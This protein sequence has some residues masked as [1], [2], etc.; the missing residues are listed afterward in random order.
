MYQDIR[1]SDGHLLFR[2][3]PER[4]IIEIVQRKTKTVVDLKD[5]RP[6]ESMFVGAQAHLRQYEPPSP[7]S[8]CHSILIGH[9][10]HNAQDDVAPQSAKEN[11]CECQDEG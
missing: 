5:Y 7:G 8:H 3:D 1:T 9:P 6:V 4:D 11:T 10:L 2:F